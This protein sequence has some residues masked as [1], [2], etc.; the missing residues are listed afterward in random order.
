MIVNRALPD[1]LRSDPG[2]GA[3]RRLRDEADEIA[4]ALDALDVPALSDPATT[5]RVLRSIATT[6]RD[7]AVVATREAELRAELERELDV[8]AVV[9]ALEDDVH[10]VAGLA[11]I[12]KALF[13]S[14]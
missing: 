3:A 9:P 7:F 11:R 1:A 10:D 14:P 6:A 12:G 13:A 4:S 2:R 8:L 5:A